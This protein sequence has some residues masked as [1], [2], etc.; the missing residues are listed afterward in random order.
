MFVWDDDYAAPGKDEELRWFGAGMQWYYECK[1]QMLGADNGE[2]AWQIQVM[3][4]MRNSQY[5]KVRTTFPPCDD[6]SS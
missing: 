1:V 2:C 5:D 6:H 4:G 3:M